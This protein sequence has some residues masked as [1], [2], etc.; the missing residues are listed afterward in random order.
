[1]NKSRILIEFKDFVEKYSNIKKQPEWEFNEEANSIIFKN[2]D[3]RHL[4]ARL[5]A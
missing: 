4:Y 2:G 1:V 5:L 3:E